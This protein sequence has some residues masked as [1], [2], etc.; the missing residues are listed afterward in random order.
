[1]LA[2]RK[3][4]R[5]AFVSNLR[6]ELDDL[7]FAFLEINRGYAMVEMS[8]LNGAPPISIANQMPDYGKGKNID[9]DRI[10][11]ELGFDRKDPDAE[12]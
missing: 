6:E 3:R 10:E 7:D 5:S 12:E 2:K 8:A 1:M 4:L 9:F 11:M